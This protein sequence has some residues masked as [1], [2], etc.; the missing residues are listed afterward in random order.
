MKGIWLALVDSVDAVI[1]LH[2]KLWKCI[3]VKASSILKQS[4]AK[5]MQS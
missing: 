3:K 2:L 1:M 4:N 5:F